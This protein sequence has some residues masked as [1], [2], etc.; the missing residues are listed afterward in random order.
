MKIQGNPIK[1]TNSDLYLGMIIHEDGVK[2]SIQSTFKARKGKAWGQV[3]V[4]KSLLNHPQLLNEGWLGAAVAIFQGI[5]PA[6]R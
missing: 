1:V 3:P 6:A 5:I 2:E 4:I